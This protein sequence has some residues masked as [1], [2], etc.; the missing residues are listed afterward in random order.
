MSLSGELYDLGG[1]PVSVGGVRGFASLEETALI[2]AAWD[3]SPPRPF[4]DRTVGFVRE[5]G[6]RVGEAEFAALVDSVRAKAA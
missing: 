1:L 3:V 5:E 2:L 4:S 6:N